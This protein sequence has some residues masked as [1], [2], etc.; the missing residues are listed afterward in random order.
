LL[1]TG[2]SDQP[3][4]QSVDLGIAADLSSGSA[5]DLASAP[6]MAS[7]PLSCGNYLYCENFEGYSGT[8]AN[9][10]KLGPWVATATGT[11]N[12]MMVDSVRPYSGG[13][14]LHITVPAG[15]P[16]RNTLNQTVQAG[17]VPGN[18]IFG[19]AMVYYSNTGGNGLAIGVHSWIF[20]ANGTVTKGGATA[21]INMGGGGAKFQLNY[22]PP[23]PPAPAGTEYSLQGGTQT[24]GKWMC[25][26]WQLDGSGTMPKNEGK[27]WVD[28]VLAL[29]SVNQNPV[30]DFAQPWTSMD[31]GFNHY[32]TTTNPIDIYLDDFALNN[33]MIPCPP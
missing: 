14:S 27:V 32:Q 5:P 13:K 12:T 10:A 24:A 21:D 3:T 18:N 22:H 4:Q 28:G 7:A 11:G 33:T 30:W 15:M 17:L 6:D 26:Q 29:D 1:G 19:R 9:A 20:N 25:V 23:S 8:V 31:F 2:C 16:T